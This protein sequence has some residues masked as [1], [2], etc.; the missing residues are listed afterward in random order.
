[1]E[2]VEKGKKNI[3]F[4]ALTLLNKPGVLEKVA[5]IFAKHGV[6]I[7]S[8]IHYG[9]SEKKESIWF[10]SAD[11]TGSDTS[12]KKIFKELEQFEPVLS[13]EYGVKEYGNILLP[14]FSIELNVLGTGI[15]VQEK[16]WL[17]EVNKAIVEE[18]GTGGEALVFHMGFKAGYRIVDYWTKTTG[19]SGETL[20]PLILEVMKIFNWIGDYK[21]VKLD[22][23]KNDLVFRVWNLMDCETFEKRMSKPTSHYFRGVISGFM[24]KIFKK[25]I[26][27]VETKC[28]AEGDSYCEFRAK[29]ERLLKL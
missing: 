21:I 5:E 3:L 1:M 14:P 13:I 10:F 15:I 6:N 23:K 8:G 27:F 18:L 22:V 4:V 2:K 17:K 19:L 29:R 11:F 16:T 24:S 7:L 20:I 25:R 12:P 28:V 9:P 26:I